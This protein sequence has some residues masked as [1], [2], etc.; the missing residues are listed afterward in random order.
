M[1]ILLSI[2]IVNYRSWARLRQCLESVLKQEYVALEVIVVDN[3]SGDGLSASFVA[4][5]PSVNFVLQDFNG[6]FA[7][8][9]NKGASLAKGEWLLFLNPDT[10]LDQPHVLAQLLRK[11]EEES[12]WKLIG[13]KQFNEAGR[14]TY[15]YGM[16]LNWWNI[17]PPLRSLERLIRG[18]T[19]SK[20]FLSGTPM[21]YPDWIS[22]SFVLIRRND[23]E[24]L[25]GWDERFWMYSE[26]MDLSRRAYDKGWKR[27]M[28][29]EL[30]CVHVHGGSSRI[31]VNTKALTKSEVIRSKYHYIQKHLLG[32]GR[33]VATLTLSMITAIELFLA[34]PFS[35][36]KR[37]M[38]HYLLRGNPYRR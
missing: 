15:P 36:V 30:S 28:Y 29:N 6:G 7:Q 12:S 21:S 10:V 5:F 25:C 24:E 11:A 14:D 37:K 3:C 23:L 8:A 32:P 18:K 9:C 16:F 13:I 34:A 35:P 33:V 20:A 2:V 22:G 17:W 19:Q 38:I 1:E 4:E 31:N 26:D 27:V